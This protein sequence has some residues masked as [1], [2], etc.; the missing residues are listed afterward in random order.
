MPT[1]QIDMKEVV[2]RNAK[3]DAAKVKEV[4]DTMAEI[5][6]HGVSRANY[7]IQSPYTRTRGAHPPSPN[8]SRL[9]SSR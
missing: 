8:P 2:R 7:E 3:V 6:K 9:R 1:Q 4:M 5:D